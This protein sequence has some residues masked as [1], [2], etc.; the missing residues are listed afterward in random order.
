MKHKG[1]NIDE[2]GPSIPVSIM[3]LSDVPNAG[4]LFEITSSERDA[5]A[6]MK[7]RELEAEE[8]AQAPIQAT[9][10]EQLFARFQSG[11]EKEL[12]LVIKADV[13]GSLEPIINSVKELSTAEIGINIILS[14]TGNIS[15]GDNKTVN[16]AGSIYIANLAAGGKTYVLEK[17]GGTWRIT[18]TTGPMWI[19]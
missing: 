11:E 18:G 5:R 7:A 9:T 3:G 4:D 15:E 16:V 8:A 12:R 2:A 6:L 19:S 14:G 13:Q 17:Q 1:Q 10:L